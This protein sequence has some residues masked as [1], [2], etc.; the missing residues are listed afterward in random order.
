MRYLYRIVQG[1]IIIGTGFPMNSVWG[2]EHRTDNRTGPVVEQSANVPDRSTKNQRSSWRYRRHNGEWWYWS[3]QE[4]WLYWRDGSWHVYVP[5]RFVVPEYRHRYPGNYGTWYYR[6]FGPRYPRAYYP[7]PYSGYWDG[8]PYYYDPRYRDPG[9]RRGANIGGPIGD[10][11]GGRLG[12]QIGAEI[13][14]D[15]GD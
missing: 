2:Q 9:F 11:I 1:L 5:D 3:P 6:D 7:H 10:V 14:G 15:I 8:N 12:A 13:G 4:R